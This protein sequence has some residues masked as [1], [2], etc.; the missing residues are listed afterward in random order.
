MDD[1]GQK[2]IAI[3]FFGFARSSQVSLKDFAMFMQKVDPSN[4]ST[5]IHIYIYA[6]SILFENDQFIPT[7]DKLDEDKF[8]EVFMEYGHD[9]N[10]TIVV[11]IQTFEYNSERFVNDAII[12]GM[13]DRL[14]GAQGQYLYRIQSLFYQ[15]SELS[16]MVMCGSDLYTHVILTR[17]DMIP[18]VR[19]IQGDFYTLGKNDIRGYRNSPYEDKQAIE[20][21]FMAMGMGVVHVLSSIFEK[22]KYVG[23]SESRLF[24]FL[25]M[26]S[27]IDILPSGVDLVLHINQDRFN[28]EYHDQIVKTCYKELRD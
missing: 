12:K 4:N 6:P 16:K 23:N 22:D 15:I 1:S 9:Y 11:Q 10:K 27:H 17:L 25:D 8:K 28:T 3:G 5:H 14:P 26:H 7:A 24:K 19:S 20:D 13:P 21:R 2:M 18:L